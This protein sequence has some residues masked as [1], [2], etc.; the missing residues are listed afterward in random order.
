MEDFDEAEELNE[1]D[2]LELKDSFAEINLKVFLSEWDIIESC[3]RTVEWV[4]IEG[5]ER[6]RLYELLRKAANTGGLGAGEEIFEVHKER[7]KYINFKF[8]IIIID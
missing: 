2:L 4:Y 3:A 1:E 5:I 7:L 6:I 8:K